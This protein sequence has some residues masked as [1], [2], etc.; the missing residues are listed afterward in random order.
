MSRG[1]TPLAKGCPAPQAHRFLHLR[2]DGVRPEHPLRGWPSSSHSPDQR[3]G[4]RFP[5]EEAVAHPRSARALKAE[6]ERRWAS[7][8]GPSGTAEAGGY[9]CHRTSTVR[10]LHGRVTPFSG[11][12]GGAARERG[13]GRPLRGAGHGQG[14][15]CLLRPKSGDVP[16]AMQRRTSRHSQ[17]H[18][19][20]ARQ[21]L[22]P[23]R[24]RTQTRQS[25]TAGEEGGVS[26]RALSALPRVAADRRM[27]STRSADGIVAAGPIPR[28]SARSR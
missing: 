15:A 7:E 13:K 19:Q 28:P 27:E 8:T 12:Q 2:P 9:C 4:E 11:W 10:R 1:R 24:S 16:P 14:P 3:S 22:A 6:A 5:S 18:G 20:G 17:P 21:A 26:R 23:T 25:P